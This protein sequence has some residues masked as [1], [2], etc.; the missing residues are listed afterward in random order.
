M[1]L[2]DIIKFCT[3][4]PALVIAVVLGIVLWSMVITVALSGGRNNAAKSE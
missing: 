4:Y 2:I 3:D 1:N